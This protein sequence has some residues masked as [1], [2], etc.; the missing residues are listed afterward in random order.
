MNKI[1]YIADSRVSNT[2]AGLGD[3][4]MK[5]IERRICTIGE[6]YC[7]ITTS[8]MTI[9]RVEMIR[10]ALNASEATIRET[11]TKYKKSTKNKIKAK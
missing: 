3:E 2:P 6:D 10:R 4:S 8:A 11:D 1:V 7:I 9:E 5:E